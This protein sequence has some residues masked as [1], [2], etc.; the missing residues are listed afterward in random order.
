MII[1]GVI[2][3]ADDSIV[4]ALHDIRNRGNIFSGM[5]GE[6]YSKTRPVKKRA[7]LT[8]AQRTYIWD[9]PRRYG[10][11]CHICGS[12]ITKLADLELDHNRAYS[13]GGSKLYLT[14]KECNRMKG[15]K[16]LSDVQTRMGF[17]KS[18]RKSSRKRARKNWH[19][20][21]NLITGNKYKVRNDSL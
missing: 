9:N 21:T 20:E 16:A 14:H 3:M 8:F 1:G 15:S 4:G 5:Y 10:R 2:S 18:K 13:K 12:R 7:K 11:K 19:W 6:T 17:K